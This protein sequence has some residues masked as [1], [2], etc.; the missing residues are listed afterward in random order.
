LVQTARGP[1]RAALGQAKG[2]K[3]KYRVVGNNSQGKELAKREK[4]KIEQGV[5]PKGVS[6]QDQKAEACCP[7][8]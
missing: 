6:N 5:R 7:A 4:E 1:T 8:G 2:E 3:A